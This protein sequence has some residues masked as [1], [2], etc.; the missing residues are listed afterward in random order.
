MLRSGTGAG[1][2]TEAIS[3]PDASW[4]TASAS[5]A[6]GAPMSLISTPAISGPVE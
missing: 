2:F 4:L 1:A 5:A 6:S 3:R